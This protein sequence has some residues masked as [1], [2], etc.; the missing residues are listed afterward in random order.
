MIVSA[1]GIREGLLLETARVV[2]KFS[3]RGEARERSV[4]EFAER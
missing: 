2:P 4:R 1:Y 3:D